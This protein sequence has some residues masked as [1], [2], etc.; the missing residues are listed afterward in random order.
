MRIR[1][2]H[3]QTGE[4]LY[5]SIGAR[6]LVLVLGGAGNLCSV[7]DSGSS[8]SCPVQVAQIES[9]SGSESFSDSLG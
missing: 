5:L 9:S 2:N 1:R 4:M 7:T 8:T 3:C 6:Q